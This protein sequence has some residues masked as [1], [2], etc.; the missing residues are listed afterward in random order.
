MNK[1][2]IGTVAVLALA[3]L[4]GSNA[5]AT[6]LTLGTPGIVGIA[7]GL[8]GDTGPGEAGL[9]QAILD[10]TGLGTAANC[11]SPARPCKSS[12]LLDYSST[13]IGAGVQGGE[14][15]VDVPAGWQDALGK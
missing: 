12:S 4:P 13:I 5:Y 14:H 2:V 6:D 1:L 9:A 10:L 11:G 3:C 15:A 8:A 7:N